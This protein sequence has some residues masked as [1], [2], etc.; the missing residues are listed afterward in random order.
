MSNPGIVPRPRLLQLRP[1]VPAGIPI[2]V[3]TCHPQRP[4]F[5][6]LRPLHLRLGL[7]WTS[8][9]HLT[10]R[11][12][13]RLAEPLTPTSCHLHMRQSPCQ[14]RTR[15]ERS[16]RPLWTRHPRRPY[17]DTTPSTPIGP[18]QSSKRRSVDTTPSRHRSHWPTRRSRILHR[19]RLR[20][21]P[22]RTIGMLRARQKRPQGIFAGLLMIRQ[23]VHLYAQPCLLPPRPKLCTFRSRQTRNC[24]TCII[25][26][27]S[28]KP[29]NSLWPAGSMCYRRT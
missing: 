13:A 11:N 14:G 24:R 21:R 28:C 2:I 5:N 26:Q 25:T 17:Q 12:Q 23:L 7:S 4:L 16:A 15:K 3:F 29:S 6:P 1:L 9:Y 22:P 20:T 8:S 27:V 18:H 19:T 10:L